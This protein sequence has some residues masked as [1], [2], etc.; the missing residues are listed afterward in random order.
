MTDKQDFQLVAPLI[1]GGGCFILC[2]LWTRMTGD[3]NRYTWKAL[4]A[5]GG[6]LAYALYLT[7]WQN[8]LKELWHSA[9]SVLVFGLLL[10]LAVPC[11]L[12]YWVWRVQVAAKAKRTR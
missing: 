1:G 9:P 10:S 2:L 8:E 4:L 12:F 3:L 6:L 5:C 7:F 11:G